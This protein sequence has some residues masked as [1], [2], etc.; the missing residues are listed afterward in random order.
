[1]RGKGHLKL[2]ALNKLV[3]QL[4]V[5]TRKRILFRLS[6]HIK[7]IPIGNISNFYLC[8][9]EKLVFRRTTVASWDRKLVLIYSWIRLEFLRPIYVVETLSLVEHAEMLQRD[10]L[11]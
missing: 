2:I 10:G 6:R 11:I 1:M 5:A 8:L 4:A 9:P 7:M 3:E